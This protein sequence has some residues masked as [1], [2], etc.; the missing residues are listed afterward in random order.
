MNWILERQPQK[1]KIW[2]TNTK[3]V[4][5]IVL[6]I[7]EIK[8]ETLNISSKECVLATMMPILSSTNIMQRFCRMTLWTLE[9]S[10]FVLEIVSLVVV[11]FYVSN[12]FKTCYVSL[13]KLHF[14]GHWKIDNV[15]E[16]QCYWLVLIVFFFEYFSLKS[17]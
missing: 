10:L 17:G 13:R 9:A 8:Q 1:K 5:T 2:W 6:E 7:D 3:N 4:Q 14:F 12:N 16:K 15:S 11:S